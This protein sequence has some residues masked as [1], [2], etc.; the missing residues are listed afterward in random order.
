[1]PPTCQELQLHLFD[2]TLL[3]SCP[4]TDAYLVVLTAAAFCSSVLLQCDT[5][6]QQA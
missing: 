1:M 5:I 3:Q 4:V 6:L 2:I